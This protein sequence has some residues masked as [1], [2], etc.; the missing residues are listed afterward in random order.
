ML[1]DIFQSFEAGMLDDREIPII[2]K[3]TYYSFNFK[4]INHLISLCLNCTGIFDEFLLI[5]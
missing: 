3:H 1:L 2:I 4:H 5:F